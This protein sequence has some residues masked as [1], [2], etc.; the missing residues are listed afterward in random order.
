M[1]KKFYQ[2]ADEYLY[3]LDSETDD[4]ETLDKHSD[5]FENK[6]VNIARVLLS[7]DDKINLINTELRRLKTLKKTMSNKH[8]SLSN[9][10]LTNLKKLNRD[11]VNYGLVDIRVKPQPN[12]IKIIDLNLIDS[13]YLK[14]TTSI[15]IDKVMVK[16]AL[17]DGATIKGLK[18]VS[19]DDKLIIKKV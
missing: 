18:Y 10:L 11:H 14:V 13:E 8:L 7:Y 6:A 5:L 1:D 17:E 16:K 9:Y 15:D 2:I 12:T 4:I 3:L 19:Q